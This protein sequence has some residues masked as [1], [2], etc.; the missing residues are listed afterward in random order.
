MPGDWQPHAM[1]REAKRSHRADRNPHCDGPMAQRQRGGP[2]RLINQQPSRG[3]K[4]LLGAAA[5]R[6]C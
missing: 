3:E 4:I 6:R 2:M 5:V 1:S